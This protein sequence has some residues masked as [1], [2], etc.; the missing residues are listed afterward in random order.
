VGRLLEDYPWPGNVREL[1][2]AIEHALVFLKNPLLGADDFPQIA[3]AEGSARGAAAGKS[4]K[5]IE[6]EA[7][8]RTLEAVHY[9]IG[10][11]AGILGISRKTLLDK[12]RKFGLL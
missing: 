6:R 11:A 9:K 10:E 3:K 4:L 2:N 5:E 1:K 8:E 12:R 7:I